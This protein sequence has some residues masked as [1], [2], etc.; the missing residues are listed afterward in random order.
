MKALLKI[1]CF[2]AV[3]L[4]KELKSQSVMEYS[5]PVEENQIIIPK[6]KVFLPPPPDIKKYICSLLKLMYTT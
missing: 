1:F 4:K 5:Q 2:A 3:A 6:L